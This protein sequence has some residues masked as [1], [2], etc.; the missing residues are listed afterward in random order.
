MPSA[1]EMIERQPLWNWAN[2]RLIDKAVGAASAVFAF[3][4]GD[5]ERPVT[6]PAESAAP[7]PA[8]IGTATVSPGE[9]SINQW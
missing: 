7:R 9:K 6:I 1:A 8:F 5:M 3:R 2:K 4:D